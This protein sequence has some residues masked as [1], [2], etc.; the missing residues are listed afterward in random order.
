VLAAYQKQPKFLHSTPENA[1]RP[2]NQNIFVDL[3]ANRQA[4]E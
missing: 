4:V 3:Q 1:S 2:S